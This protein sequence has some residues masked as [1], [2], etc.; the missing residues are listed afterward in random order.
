ML[1]LWSPSFSSVIIVLINA[2]VATVRPGGAWLG[3]MAK[4]LKPAFLRGVLE[5]R[6]HRIVDPWIQ[7]DL[8]WKWNS[9]LPLHPQQD[10]LRCVGVCPTSPHV[11]CGSGEGIQMCPSGSGVSGSLMRA[12]CSLCNQSQESGPQRR[13]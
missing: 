5:R 3:R 4:A 10:P 8:S 9:G 11:F 13:Q 12:V 2:L 7:E 6:V 1:R